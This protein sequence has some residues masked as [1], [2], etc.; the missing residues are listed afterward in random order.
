M[1]D[2]YSVN[3]YELTPW[4]YFISYYYD[5]TVPDLECPE[6]LKQWEYRVQGMFYNFGFSC[7]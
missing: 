4:H 3:N 7:P 5:Y 6:S 1:A 2:E